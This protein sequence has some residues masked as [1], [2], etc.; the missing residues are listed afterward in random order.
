MR[1]HDLA[2]TSDLVR[3]E[4]EQLEHRFRVSFRVVETGGDVVV[5]VLA[6]EKTSGVSIGA[7][8][9]AST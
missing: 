1:L 6:H 3:E 2:A 9:L 5:V 4:V 8:S 7:P